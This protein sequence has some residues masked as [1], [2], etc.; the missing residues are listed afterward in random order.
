MRPTV[1]NEILNVNVFDSLYPFLIG[2]KGNTA[3]R[4]PL[5]PHPQRVG[6]FRFHPRKWKI[7]WPS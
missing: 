4:S 2:P 5:P 3:R 7:S 6:V 1:D